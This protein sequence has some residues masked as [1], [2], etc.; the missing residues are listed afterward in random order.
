V[1]GRHERIVQWLRISS[2]LGRAPRTIDAYARGLSGYLL[3]LLMCEQD[4]VDP[5]SA[6]HAHVAVYV[7]ELTS[8]AQRMGPKCGL[9]R[10]GDRAGQRHDP[11]ACG[12]CDCS[13]TSRLRRG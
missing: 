8:R 11:A 6:N 13:T 1:L 10:L 12:Q 9:D 3:Y 4:E 7:R 2:D 5:L